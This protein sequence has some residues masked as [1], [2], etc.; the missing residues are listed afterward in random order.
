MLEVCRVTEIQ[1]SSL[2][3]TEYDRA[4]VPPHNGNDPPPAPGSLKALL[5]ATPIKQSTKQGN[6]RGTSEVRRGTS[7]NHF[8]CPVPRSSSHIGPRYWSLC[9]NT[10]G[11]LSDSGRWPFAPHQSIYHCTQKDYQ[12]NSKTVSVR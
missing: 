11:Y 9:R 2:V 12:I 8:H 3:D 7:S 1:I 10:R 6:A 5:F 4:K